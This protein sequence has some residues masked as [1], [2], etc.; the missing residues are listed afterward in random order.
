MAT[1]PIALAV[2]T[3]VLVVG[4]GFILSS[5]VGSSM[6]VSETTSADSMHTGAETLDIAHEASSIAESQETNAIH[7]FIPYLAAGERVFVGLVDEIEAG[8]RI[9]LWA[10]ASEGSGIFIGLSDTPHL[11]N[12]GEMLGTWGTPF[13]SSADSGY[14]STRGPMSSDFVYLYIGALGR[15]TG[16]SDITIYVRE[17]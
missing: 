8:Q 4:G 7:F 16:L 9:E 2:V 6:P 17:L 15:G 11:S 3:A 12:H 5:L 1:R 13:S 10:E 14:V